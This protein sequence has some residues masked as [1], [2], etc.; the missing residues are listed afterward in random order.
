[1]VHGRTIPRS[2][3]MELHATTTVRELCYACEQSV[4]ALPISLCWRA[5]MANR[6]QGKRTLIYGGGTGIGYACA[7]AMAREGA[8]VF[9][10]SRREEVLRQA[11]EKLS[12][13]GRAGFAAGDATIADD[14]ER[15]TATADA[16][17]KGID[18]ILISSGTSGRT[19]IFSTPPDEFQRIIDHN[20]RP[21]FLAVRCSVP[22]LLQAGNASVI[23]IASM[24]GLVGQYERVAYCAAKAGVLGM[25]RAMA[26]DFADKGVRV[27]AIAPGAIDTELALQVVRKEPDPEA[28]LRAR[29]SMHPIPRAGRPE[30]IG[31]A[32]VYLASDVAA[33]MTGQCL[34]VDGGY[35]A[36]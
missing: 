7:E 26:L 2:L 6:L 23:A 3:F 19:S 25:V 30:E 20:L 1:M 8:A 28:A 17:L 22:Q 5:L 12:V 32:A 24:W 18:T 27:N 34:T 16:F 35:T 33:F 4:Q 36:R 13:H 29:H 31:E 15:I 10:S 21:V 9:V 11:V 14:V